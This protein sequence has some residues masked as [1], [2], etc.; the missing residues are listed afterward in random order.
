MTHVAPGLPKKRHLGPQNGSGSSGPEKLLKIVSCVENY[1]L[2]EMIVGV[3]MESVGGQKYPPGSL[4]P[5][6]S[7]GSARL[8]N[9]LKIVSCVEVEKL[10]ELVLQVQM[11]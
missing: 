1:K 9:P 7:F 3:Q 8:E 5:Q 11:E 10:K 2:K 4:S 6:N